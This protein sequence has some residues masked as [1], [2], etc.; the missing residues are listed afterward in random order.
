MEDKHLRQE[1]TGSSKPQAQSESSV[2]TFWD[3]YNRRLQIEAR[4]IYLVSEVIDTESEEV[5][6]TSCQIAYSVGEK[7]FRLFV[8]RTYDE[9][10][11]EWQVKKKIAP[12]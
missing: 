10:R 7:D 1:S 2:M 8:A 3:S 12:R 6:K 11:E 4:R 9:V 5:S